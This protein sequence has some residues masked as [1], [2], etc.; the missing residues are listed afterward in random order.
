VRRVSFSC[1]ALPDSFSAV[2]RAS[3]PVFMCSAPG[4]VFGGTVGVGYRYH[5]LSSQTRFRRCRVRRVPYSCF[6]LSDSFSAVPRASGPVFMC[7]APGLVYDGTV[8]VGNRFHVLSSQTRFRCCRV[9]RVPHSC[10]A[11]PDS[12][13]AVPRVSGPVFMFGAPE[14]VFRGTEGI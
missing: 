7:S 8:G 12:F 3:D 14:L 13:S 4:L 1:F 11:L 10:F 5:V 2:P 9:R 6:A